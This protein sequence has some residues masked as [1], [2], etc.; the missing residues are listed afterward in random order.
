[1]AR[2]DRGWVKVHRA[3]LEHPVSQRGLFTFGVFMRLLYMANWKQ[4]SVIFSGEKVTLQPGQLVTGLRE[5]SPC[6]SEDPYLNKVRASL[7][8]L[9]L[10]GAIEQVSNNQGRLITICN[11]SKYQSEDSDELAFTT[12]EAQAEHKQATSGPQLSKESK[13]EESKKE[14]GKQTRANALP[15]LA[16]IWNEHCGKLPK[17][18]ACGKSRQKHATVRWAENPNPDYWTDIVQ[19]IAQSSFCNG[20]GKTGWRADF[21]FL[22]QPETQHKVLEGKYDAHAV[23]ADSHID[24]SQVFGERSA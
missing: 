2:F 12:S 10:C 11:W 13:K 1:M 6:K 23:A 15:R 8:Y 7:D 21:D 22:I 9:V 5:L 24:W 3:V 4:S 17:V 14:E 16:E 19:R 18:R 20:N